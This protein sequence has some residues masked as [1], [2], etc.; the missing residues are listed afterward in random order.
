MLFREVLLALLTGSEDIECDSVEQW[1]TL[2]D[3]AQTT[4]PAMDP[5]PDGLI[6]MCSQSIVDKAQ[7]FTA[8]ALPT[9]LITTSD[10]RLPDNRLYVRFRKDP[11]K[12]G[13]IPWMPELATTLPITPSDAT[14]PAVKLIQPRNLRA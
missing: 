10:A 4:H 7:L 12:F 1:Q 11:L 13:D 3:L 2:H 14:P 8:G 6:I 5:L 9:W